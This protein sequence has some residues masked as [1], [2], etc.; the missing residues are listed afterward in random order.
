MPVLFL[1]DAANGVAEKSWQASIILA[2]WMRIAQ[3]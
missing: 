2:S 1:P 3:V